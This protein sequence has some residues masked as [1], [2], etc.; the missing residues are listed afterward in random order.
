ML[1][2]WIAG[3]ANTVES[4]SIRTA[5][6]VR[7]RGSRALSIVALTINQEAEADLIFGDVDVRCLT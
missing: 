2:A 4:F 5:R 1:S 7:T 6:S 3:C